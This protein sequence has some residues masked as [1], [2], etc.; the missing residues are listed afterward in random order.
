MPMEATEPKQETPS[1]TVFPVAPAQHGPPDD[2]SGSPQRV[3]PGDKKATVVDHSSVV[4]FEPD[5]I[6]LVLSLIFRQKPI[7]AGAWQTS[8]ALKEA[9]TSRGAG[10]NSHGRVV[11]SMGSAHALVCFSVFG[12]HLLIP[13]C[14]QVEGIRKDMQLFSTTAASCAHLTPSPLFVSSRRF[15]FL[16]CKIL[17]HL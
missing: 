6:R 16:I 11:Y 1:S 13:R 17:R 2:R 14:T 3:E 9:G 7:L 10:L 4:A 15:L 8:A 5:P 12:G